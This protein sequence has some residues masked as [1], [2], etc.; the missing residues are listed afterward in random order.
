MY[1]IFTSICVK[2]RPNEAKY[3][4]HGS[5]GSWNVF[6]HIYKYVYLY[7]YIDIRVPSIIWIIRF[8]Q[9]NGFSDS[10]AKT[11]Y[12]YTHFQVILFNVVFTLFYL[13]PGFPTIVLKCHGFHHS[14]VSVLSGGFYWEVPC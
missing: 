10:D 8:L 14:L 11:I 6:I 9:L 13:S 12:I 3:T 4:I 2:H 1:G 5:N 7:I